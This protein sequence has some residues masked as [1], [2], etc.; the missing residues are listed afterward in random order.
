MLLG[1]LNYSGF[2]P[3]S[4]LSVL[5]SLGLFVLAPLAVMAGVTVIWWLAVS[6]SQSRSVQRNPDAAPID[7]Q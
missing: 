1:Y 3:T 4:E 2:N 7:W 6:P 5:E